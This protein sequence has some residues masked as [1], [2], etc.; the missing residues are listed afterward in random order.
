VAI[1]LVQSKSGTG[2]SLSSLT[3]TFTSNVTAGNL[4][5]VAVNLVSNSASITSV[6][7]GTTALTLANSKTLTG[8]PDDIAAIYYLANAPSGQN[9]ITITLSGSIQAYQEAWCT[10]W[11]GCATSG[12][13]DVAPSG[14]TSTSGTWTS[15]S[16]G[17]LSQAS[18]VIIGAAGF[19]F[20]A[21][22]SVTSPGSPW[23]ELGTLSNS[24]TAAL[25]TGYQIVSATTAQT[26]SGTT[27][28][29]NSSSAVITSFKASTGTT[30]AISD[31]AVSIAASA[32]TPGV[33]VPVSRASVS[34][35]ASPVTPFI[36][37]IVSIGTA[38]VSVAAEALTP[39]LQ[40]SINPASVSVAASPLTP[41]VFRK[42][43]ISIASQSGTD[44][45]GNSYPEGLMVGASADGPQVGLVPNPGGAA[46]LRFPVPALSLSN[47]GNV[48]ADDNYLLVSGPALSASGQNDWVQVQQITYLGA[49]DTASGVLYYIDTSGVAH[50]CARWSKTGFAIPGVASPPPAPSIVGECALY[51]YGDT[52]YA[53]GNSGIP[54]AIANT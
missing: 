49:E 29:G 3:V 39:A 9:T 45:Y 54:V 38:S 15:N 47:T 2:T 6:K 41:S 4:V 20:G 21:G 48:A 37:T 51:Y 14:G 18:E 23:T 31:A 16:S 44:A 34:V 52:L 13:L 8:S 11:S 12:V 25:A 17:T 50:A 5:A 43:I 26:Y 53:V 30:V 7:L 1:S 42:L 33:T 24:S 19:Y 35:A 10:E 28:N 32:L 46:E 22:T 40:V 36:G 27:T